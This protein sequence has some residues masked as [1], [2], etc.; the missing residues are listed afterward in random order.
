MPPA[1]AG[2]ESAPPDG[3]GDTLQNLAQIYLDLGEIRRAVA[4]GEQALEIAR[5]VG[6]RRLEGYA[7]GGLACAQAAQGQGSQAATTF[8]EAT[9]LLSEVGDR[10]GVAMCQWQAGLT[11]H[12]QGDRQPALTLL[13][14]A[15][16]Y[17]QEIGHAQASAHAERLARLEADP[18]E[19]P[20]GQRAPS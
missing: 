13:R 10:W 11:L 6:A 4:A 14:A 2:S 20:A 5:A 3:E 8:A 12:Q 17:W 9:A 1:I 15:L 18:S 19:A 7:L 16:A